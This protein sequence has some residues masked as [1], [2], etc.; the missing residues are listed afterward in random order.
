MLRLFV[1]SVALVLGVGSVASGQ[2]K[3][4]PANSSVEKAVKSKIERATVLLRFECRERILKD[5]DD[6]DRVLVTLRSLEQFASGAFIGRDGYVITAAHTIEQLTARREAH[7]FEIGCRKQDIL[8]S[9]Y[10]I[11]N[12]EGAITGGRSSGAKPD[13]SEDVGQRNY[14]MEEH[15]VLIFKFR[16]FGGSVPES[17]CVGPVIA[18]ER[19]AHLPIVAA[20]VGIEASNPEFEVRPGFATAESGGDGKA[21]RNLRMTPAATKGMSGGPV[22]TW[23]GILVGLV[24]GYRPAENPLATRNHFVPQ[25]WFHD[26]L[27]KIGGSCPPASSLRYVTSP[28]TGLTTEPRIFFQLDNRAGAPTVTVHD[29]RV[30]VAS[31]PFFVASEVFEL[32]PVE[33]KPLNE[34]GLNQRKIQ[35]GEDSIFPL[36]AAVDV[37]AGESKTFAANVQLPASRLRQIGDSIIRLSLKALQ[38]GQEL[39][40]H[41]DEIYYVSAVRGLRR[42]PVTDV[43]NAIRR[44]ECDEETI[45]RADPNL[46]LTTK[47]LTD[48]EVNAENIFFELANRSEQCW[49][50]QLFANLL[51]STARTGLAYS[52]LLAKAE[53]ADFAQ[54][55]HLILTLLTGLLDK[56]FNEAVYYAVKLSTSPDHQP[57]SVMN[58]VQRSLVRQALRGLRERNSPDS[59]LARFQALLP[60]FGAALWGEICYLAALESIVHALASSCDRGVAIEDAKPEKYRYSG[61]SMA[62]GIF[63]AL[64]GD[65]EGALADFRDFLERFSPVGGQDARVAGWIDMLKKG[66]NPITPEILLALEKESL[67]PY[68]NSIK[69]MRD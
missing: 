33:V 66:Q 63:R 2:A 69:S 56:D 40:V 45:A 5:A 39:R 30:A 64:S 67:T 50:H 28:R 29:I 21:S 31:Q 4:Q 48:D 9:G 18:R 7:G 15:D 23:D 57:F 44:F 49:G 42:V 10:K 22:T 62:R 46:S 51:V 17:L 59:S 38:D 54:H 65:H 24:Q 13:F 55:R 61:A 6:S 53:T 14:G 12:I 11:S 1:I 32:L 16:T 25:Y 60:K 27:T 8:I 36:T 3:A 34:A 37:P 43:F 26:P 68:G 58:A 20:G 52:N 41:S 35:I 19:F 47:L